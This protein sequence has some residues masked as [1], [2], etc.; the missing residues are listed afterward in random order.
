MNSFFIRNHMFT[1]YGLVTKLCPTL[2]TLF[3]RN[4]GI[5]E[6]SL[7]GSSVHGILQAGMLEWVAI[8]FSRGLSH[9]SDRTWISRIA[10]KF[11]T[12]WTTREVICT[13]IISDSLLDST[14]PV[15]RKLQK[16]RDLVCL[17]QSS[18]YQYLEQCL[19]LRSGAIVGAL[20]IFIEFIP[21]ILDTTCLPFM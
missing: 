2:K 19:V 11:F 7:P 10:G 20:H 9:P 17:V 4:I 5:Q 1:C 18:T 16:A 8:S 15:A 12:I 3:L 6:Y 13:H 14:L 21:T